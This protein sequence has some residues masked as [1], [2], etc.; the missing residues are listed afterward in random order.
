MTR[1]LLTAI[2]LTLLLC[3]SSFALDL[4]S[5]AGAS[6]PSPLY[7]E[8]AKQYSRERSVKV[9]YDSIGSGGGIRAIKSRSVDFGAS[10]AP[11]LPQ[12]LAREGLIQF[13]TVIG[14]VVPVV[15]VQGVRPGAMQLDADVLCGIFMGEI[16]NWNDDRI[17]SLNPSLQLP[18]HGIVV[19]HRS[20]ESGTTAIFTDYLSKVCSNW[21]RTVGS[22]KA[23]NW[24]AGIGKKGNEGVAQY[25]KETQNTIGYTEFSFAG[26][27][28]IAHTKLKNAYGYF[29]E[30][31][32]EGFQTAAAKGM[33][34]PGL[35]VL[36]KDFYLWL[37]NAPGK[38]TW[39]ITGAT[40][41]LLTKERVAVNERVIRFIDWAY[42]NGD[43]RAQ[44]LMYF[45]LPPALK[46]N[47]A[48]YWKTHKINVSY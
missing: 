7:Q 33:Y 28:A 38:K 15:H 25:V 16:T 12:D 6:F 37:T 2:T 4:L 21:K 3:S 35:P 5:G 31:T 34:Y 26:Q 30:P 22:G 48:L 23:V 29:V 27:Y 20:D 17:A 11:L 42:R 1:T 46:E 36:K 43:A 13:P 10:D 41:I 47:V 40:F 24:P 32:V 8:W 14:G 9:S 44:K 45:P 39:P 18:K 19:V